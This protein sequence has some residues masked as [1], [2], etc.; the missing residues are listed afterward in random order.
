MRVIERCVFV[1]RDELRDPVDP[2]VTLALNQSERSL[3]QQ[4]DTPEAGGD[5]LALAFESALEDRIVAHRTGAQIHQEPAAM[6]IERCNRRDQAVERVFELLHRLERTVGP[7]EAHEPGAAVGFDREV[8]GV[9]H[10]AGQ[11]NGTADALRAA[12]LT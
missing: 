11:L 12:L 7:T 10:A 4:R 1:G 5:A 9:G 8:F 3:Y 2:S 6:P